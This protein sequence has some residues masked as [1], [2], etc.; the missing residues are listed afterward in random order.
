M[1][2][3][4]F[5]YGTL[6]S[7]ESRNYSLRWFGKYVKDM[8][9]HGFRLYHNFEGD[10]PVL[11]RT[12]NVHDIVVGEL[13]ELKG[14]SHDQLS[15]LSLLDDI[16][17]VPYLYCRMSVTVASGVKA[18]TYCGN[19]NERNEWSGR[20]DLEAWPSGARWGSRRAAEYFEV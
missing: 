11:R 3:Y 8:I 16:E 12:D 18:V 6:M 13:W 20:G 1:K 17:G 14:D 15:T 9:V 19:W 5:V 10:Y 7:G 4:L 2:T